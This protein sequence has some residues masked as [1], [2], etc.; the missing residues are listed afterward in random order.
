MSGRVVHHLQGAANVRTSGAGN[1]SLMTVV[2]LMIALGASI[3][4]FGGPEEFARAV[5]NVV[6]DVVEGGITF[7][8]SL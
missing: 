3:L 4:L 7:A 8:K 5:N 6:R 2:I 1:E